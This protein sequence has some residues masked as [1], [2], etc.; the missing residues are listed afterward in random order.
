M[1]RTRRARAALLISLFLFSLLLSY[2][3]PPARAGWLSGWSYRKRHIINPASG[4]GTGYQIRIIA[5]YGSGT[6]S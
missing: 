1:E 3:A 4:A 2:L 5:H 6:D